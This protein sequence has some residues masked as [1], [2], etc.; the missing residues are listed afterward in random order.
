MASLLALIALA[1]LAAKSFVE[2]RVRRE[3]VLALE[4]ARAEESSQ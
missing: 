4:P 2:W 1:T 3:Y